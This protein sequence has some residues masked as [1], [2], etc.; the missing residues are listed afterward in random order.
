MLKPILLVPPK[1]CS[2]CG[3]HKPRS[4]FRKRAASKDGLRPSCKECHS[5]QSADWQNRNIARVRANYEKWISNN[6]AHIQD[7]RSE[8]YRKNKEKVV[9]RVV[10]RHKIKL[11][12]CE[13]YKAT[14]ALRNLTSQAF[15]RKGYKKGSKC[16]QLLGCD[17]AVAKAHLESRFAPGMNWANHGK[18]HIDH[19]VPLSSAKTLAE[20]RKLCHYTNLQ[21][22]WAEDNMRK[23]GKVNHATRG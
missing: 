23:S 22:L 14:N 18:W 19:V 17:F 21:P 2:R 16:Y 15:A 8:Y 20:R 9:A 3:R 7:Y 12:T 11:A 6:E 10:R 4:N 5:K 13:L 1:K